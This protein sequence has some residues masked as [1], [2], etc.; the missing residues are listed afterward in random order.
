[1]GFKKIL[2]KKI[3]QKQSK[4]VVN[5]FTLIYQLSQ[6]KKCL[7]YIKSLMLVSYVPTFNP[8]VKIVKYHQNPIKKRLFN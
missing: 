6:M 7:E 3:R 1:M 2:F 5:P 4:Q 8:R